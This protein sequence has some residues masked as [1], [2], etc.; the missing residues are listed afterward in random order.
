MN[1][2]KQRITTAIVALGV[3]AGARV[4]QADQTVVVEK[5]T[6]TVRGPER[7]ERGSAYNHFMLQSGVLILGL[8]YGASA[9][10]AASSDHKGDNNLWI[11]V[12]GPWLDLA[13]RNDNCPAGSDRPGC[14]NET[15]YKVLLVGDGIFQ[16][17]GALDIIGAF[18]FQDTREYAKAQSQMAQSTKVRFAPWAL[19]GAGGV[20]AFG[21][22]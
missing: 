1:R 3:I 2:Q 17:I 5:P 10:V 7:V 14:R 9:V 19:P 11:P 13:N 16:A 12:V 4:A 20:S 6:T 21:R 18:V 8:S 22:F 15:I